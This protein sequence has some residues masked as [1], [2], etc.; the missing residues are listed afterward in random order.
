MNPKHGNNRNPGNYGLF[1]L[2]VALYISGVVAFSAW[3]YN[4]H[5]R[6]LLNHVDQALVNAT[7]A[8][9]QILGSLSIECAIKTGSI[10][11]MGYAEDRKK[12]EHFADAC[13][14]D[15]TGVLVREGSNI[16][17]LVA[18]TRHRGSV[19]EGDIHFRDRPAPQV[20]AAIAKLVKSEDS[21]TRVQN[22]L[23]EKYGPLRLAVRYHSLSPDT[24]YVLA[25]SQ[26]IGPFNARI[27]NLA[28]HTGI[29][30]LFLVAMAFP[31]IFLYN[32][33]LSKTTRQLAEL[34]T[35]LQQDV[36]KQK[37][38]EAELKDAIR[39]LERFNAVTLG[40]ENRIIELKAEI[41]TL[42]E[43]M[44]RKKRY[45]VNPEK[46]PLP[47]TQDGSST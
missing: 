38:R 45:N 43:Q 34:N 8:T 9:E 25:V 15:A 31:L 24:G 12:L 46:Q 16:W 19:P 10:Q 3:S 47:D 4:Q 20:A 2:A 36:S 14:F 23:H 13:G 29:T 44:K 32:R 30:G 35:R 22:I 27:R 1:A 18:G 26:D 28:I 40:R 17:I 6:L 7:Q 39:D 42:L 21:D 11:G 41:N 5:R 33:A 37:K